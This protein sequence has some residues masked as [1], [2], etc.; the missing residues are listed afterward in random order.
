MSK[1]Y[2][3]DMRNSK[4]GC[5]ALGLTPRLSCYKEALEVACSICDTCYV[6]LGTANWALP[7]LRLMQN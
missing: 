4:I 5:H 7:Q 2:I 3:S 6:L 1:L